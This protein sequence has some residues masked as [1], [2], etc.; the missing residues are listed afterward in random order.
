VRTG[1]YHLTVKKLHQ[2]YGPVVR[3]GPNLLDLDYP[4][5]IK[6]LYNADAKW[7]KVYYRQYLTVTFTT[8]AHCSLTLD[9]WNR[10]LSIITTALSLMAR[11]I[12]TCSA[13][14]TQLRINR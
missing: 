8:I 2:Q 13:C 11:S 5:L 10:L 14:R 7:L 6:T 3:L 4:E 12:T 1:S 9:E